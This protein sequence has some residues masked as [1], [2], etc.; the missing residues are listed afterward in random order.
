M[1]WHDRVRLGT[2][3]RVGRRG[4]CNVSVALGKVGGQ[5][6]YGAA[7]F[8]GFRQPDFDDRCQGGVVT[9][10]WLSWGPF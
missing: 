1:A 8:G 10:H 7:G 6:R 5:G 9:A 3:G 2:D 4:A